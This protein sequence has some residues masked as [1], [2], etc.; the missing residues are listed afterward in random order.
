MCKQKYS[1]AKRLAVHIGRAHLLVEQFIPDA[2]KFTDDV[3]RVTLSDKQCA[4]NGSTSVKPEQSSTANV[5]REQSTLIVARYYDASKTREMLCPWCS[6]RVQYNNKTDL[7]YHYVRHLSKQL[8]ELNK[9]DTVC[10]FC[11]REVLSKDIARHIG[12]KHNKVDDFIPEHA[13]Y[14]S[15][16][17]HK[18]KECP[19]QP[20]V[21]VDQSQPETEINKLEAAKTSA[22]STEE[23]FEAQDEKELISG[24][25]DAVKP[26]DPIENVSIEQQISALPPLGSSHYIPG[27]TR[28]L[29]CPWCKRTVQYNIKSELYNHFIQHLQMEIRSIQASDVLCNICGFEAKQGVR[30]HV[31]FTHNKIEEFIPEYAKYRPQLDDRTS[32]VKRDKTI[33][34]KRTDIVNISNSDITTDT[35][36]ATNTAESIVDITAT[37]EKTRPET[38]T[39]DADYRNNCKPL[40][41]SIKNQVEIETKPKKNNRITAKNST[42]FFCKKDVDSS[43]KTVLYRHYVT[44]FKDDL[45]EFNNSSTECTFCE[46]TLSGEKELAK[47]IGVTHDKI[48][49]LIP[50]HAKFDCLHK[51]K[52]EPNLVNESSSNSKRSRQPNKT[53]KKLKGIS[54]LPSPHKSTA[55]TTQNPSKPTALVKTINCFLCQ[56]SLPYQKAHLYR[57]YTKHFKE[58]LMEHHPARDVCA[59]CGNTQSSGEMPRHLAITHELI[60]NFIPNFA[61]FVK[62]KEVELSMDCFECS[63]KIIYKNKVELYTHYKQ[64]LR[65]QELLSLNPHESECSVCGLEVGAEEMEHHLGVEHDK[66]ELFIPDAAKFKELTST[67]TSSSSPI[68]TPVALLAT[69]TTSSS[70]PKRTPVSLSTTATSTSSQDCKYEPNRSDLKIVTEIIPEMMCILEKVTEA[71]KE[72]KA[73]KFGSI[74]LEKISRKTKRNEDWVVNK[75]FKKKDQKVRPQSPEVLNETDKDSDGNQGVSNV[76]AVDY[77]VGNQESFFNKKEDSAVEANTTLGYNENLGM[78]DISSVN[79]DTTYEKQDQNRSFVEPEVEGTFTRRLRSLS[80]LR[81]PIAQSSPVVSRSNSPE[82]VSSSFVVSRPNSPVP[83]QPQVS[84]SPEPTSEHNASCDLIEDL[85]ETSFNASNSEPSDEFIGENDST[86]FYRYLDSK[87]GEEACARPKSRGRILKRKS[88]SSGTSFISPTPKS[89]RKSRHKSN[90]NSSNLYV[91]DKLPSSPNCLPVKIPIFKKKHKYY[92]DEDFKPSRSKA[93]KSKPL[94]SAK[95]SVKK[96]ITGK[97]SSILGKF[98]STAKTKKS[99]NKITKKKTANKAVKPGNSVQK[100]TGVN[101]VSLERKSPCLCGEVV[102]PSHFDHITCHTCKNK[103]HANCVCRDDDSKLL[104]MCQPCHGSTTTVCVCAAQYSSSD[105]FHQCRSCEMYFHPKCLDRS[106]FSKKIVCFKCRG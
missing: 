86:K 72:S 24:E 31:A 102:A 32:K 59:I 4:E 73:I 19:E 95:R 2:A 62:E 67:D 63:E 78:N 51:I 1:K 92:E 46:K 74:V 58:K 96:K 57:H 29:E 64:H 37:A 12:V 76:D 88:Q 48:E 89:K 106:S 90:D 30:K 85:S 27:K 38:E 45:L 52:I 83:G 39:A 77:I 100:A 40:P 28:E 7:N 105:E 43:Q 25:K 80:P 20:K 82:P 68:R 93:T 71:P 42:C 26:T 8:R 104:W 3:T 16:K 17:L 35:A 55:P 34:N 75:K 41:E 23:A 98:K 44:H 21:S 9:S 66:V 6:R 103:F 56:E 47:H 10:D 101:G 49:I 61:R 5:K 18:A 50:E 13:K 60:H 54:S 33:K 97:V 69:Y 15:T 14:K 84:S 79:S 53:T 87:K 22:H 94:K 81:N 11:N 99:Q 91:E 36:N 70:S 65:K